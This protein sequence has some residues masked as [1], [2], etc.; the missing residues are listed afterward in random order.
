MKKII[1]KNL[2]AVIFDMDGVLIN[3]M[4]YH[5]RSWE[6]AFKEFNIKP[7]NTDLALHEGMSYKETIDILSKKYG[8][9]LS[10]TQ[11]K[12]IHTEKERILHSIFK[13]VIYKDIKPLLIYLKKQNLKLAVVTGSNNQ[14]A[15]NVIKKHFKEF[16]DEIITGDDVKHSKPSPE[17]YLDALKKLRFSA[18]QVIVIENAPLGILS[19]KRAHIKTIALQT[20]LPRKELARADMIFK[21]HK[22][23]LYYFRIV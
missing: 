14:F 3:S 21:N 19:A 4:P 5:I 7:T 9:T 13:F 16:F 1:T 15:K 22:E 17:P 18:H 12:K 23:L 11:K 6:D 20:T 8:V 2:K 10:A